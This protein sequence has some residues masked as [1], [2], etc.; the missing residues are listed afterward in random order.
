MFSLKILMLK[1]EIVCTVMKVIIVTVTDSAASIGCYALLLCVYWL[2]CS[3][4]LRLLVAMLCYCDHDH[5]T[6]IKNA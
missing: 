3:V 5:E 6:F 1:I 2:L 4:L